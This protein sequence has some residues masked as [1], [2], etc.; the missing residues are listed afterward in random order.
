MPAQPSLNDDQVKA[1]AEY[2]KSLGH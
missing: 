2:V 1:L